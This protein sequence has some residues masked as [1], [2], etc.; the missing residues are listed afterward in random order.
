[1]LFSLGKCQLFG[2]GADIKWYGGM[3]YGSQIL[4][5]MVAKFG[6]G[7]YMYVYV[8]DIIGPL[9]NV[10]VGDMVP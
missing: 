7:P 10:Q 8:A 6:V 5:S 3:E 1:M 4:P 9:D 2:S